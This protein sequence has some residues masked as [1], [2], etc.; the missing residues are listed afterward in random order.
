MKLRI[1]SDLHT[2]FLRMD[3]VKSFALLALPKFQ[4]DGDITLILAGDIGSMNE[5]EIL[6][7]FINE[8]APRFKEVLYIA[9]NHEY[10]GGDL[11]ETP[12]T[13]MDFLSHVPNIR[14]NFGTYP[15][16]GDRKFIGFTMWTNF[17]GQNP[18]SMWE[19]RQRMNDYRLIKNGHRI[20]QP[21]DTLE[22]H[23]GTIMQLESLINEGDI[24]ITHH[25]P[26]LKSLPVEYLHDRVNGAYHSDLDDLILRKKPSLWVHGHTHTAKR[27]NIEGT[28][29]VCNPR[30]Y[31]N[32]YKKNG[33]NPILVVEV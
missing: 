32:Q 6:V 24:V 28:E 8:V 25:S 1:C 18:V 27:Y 10:Y 33:Y 13:I 12:Q 31:G 16:D 3:E 23:N 29:I 2:E 5:P 7:A 9:G 15:L 26:S 30:G 11:Q 17:D 4:D 20:A 14:F 19:A 22:I 21:M